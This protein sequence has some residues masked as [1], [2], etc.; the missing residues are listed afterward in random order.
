MVSR[1]PLRLFPNFLR[2]EAQ[3]VGFPCPHL[4]FQLVASRDLSPIC[5]T[6]TMLNADEKVLLASVAELASPCI[7][8][9]SGAIVVR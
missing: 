9:L 2:Y 1:A 4:L 3:L 6:I 7:K 8:L 5:T